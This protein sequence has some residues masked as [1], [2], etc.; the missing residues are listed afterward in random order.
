MFF[1]LLGAEPDDEGKF[2]EIDAEVLL[3]GV[4]ECERSLLS[5]VAALHPEIQD[6]K[7]ICPKSVEDRKAPEEIIDQE[8]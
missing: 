3:E 4:P 5:D 8:T 6:A 1:K 2:S 7:T